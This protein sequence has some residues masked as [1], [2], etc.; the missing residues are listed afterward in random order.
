MDFGGTYFCEQ[1]VF[2][3]ED[4]QNIPQ[5]SS[6]F[7]RNRLRQL[8]KMCSESKSERSTNTQKYCFT[9]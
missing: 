8:L 3:D 9:P 2:C 5:G 1:N 6:G 4:A 7:D